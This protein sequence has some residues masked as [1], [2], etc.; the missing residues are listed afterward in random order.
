MTSA[1]WGDLMVSRGEDGHAGARDA[2][3]GDVFGLSSWLGS[4][5]S[6]GDVEGGIP[7]EESA[8]GSGLWPLSGAGSADATS[9]SRTD[10]FRAFVAMLVAGVTFFLMAVVFLC[11][12]RAARSRGH[13]QRPVARDCH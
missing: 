1:K 5:E 2:G 8:A 4:S 11:V 6:E 7:Q 9:M 12:P 13:L 3:Q 10:R